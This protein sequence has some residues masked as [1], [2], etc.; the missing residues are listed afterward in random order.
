LV[1]G[2]GHGPGTLDMGGSFSGL[3][4]LAFAAGGNWTLEGSST[5]VAGPDITGFAA[6]DTIIVDGFV[7]VPA[8]DTFTTGGLVLTNSAASSV[9]LAI[10]GAFQTKSFA[11]TDNASGGTDVA[12]VACFAAGT[13]I[14]TPGGE[15]PIEEL[16]TGDRVVSAFGGSVPIDW[17]GRRRLECHRHP[18]PAEIWPVRV[19]AHAFAP[20]QPSRDLRLSPDHA[21]YADEVLIP[22]RTLVNGT[23]IVQEPLDTITYFHV[24]LP[25]HDVIYADGLPAESYLD[26]GNRSAFEHGGPARVLHPDFAQTVWNA[27]ASAPQITHGPIHAAVVARLRA[28]ATARRKHAA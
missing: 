4:V 7:A 18:R 12:Y 16:H 20:G 21:V 19:R 14:L 10:Q 8:S 25:Q 26:T 27:S 9:T 5:G 6:H 3:S 22:I 2:A 11:V 24:E 28:R 17:I 23:T 1:L 15:V 13:R